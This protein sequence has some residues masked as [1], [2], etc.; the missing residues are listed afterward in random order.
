MENEMKMVFLTVDQ[1]EALMGFIEDGFVEGMCNNDKPMRWAW[2][3]SDVYKKL[4]EV[5][6]ND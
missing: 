6:T 1:C 2:N 3:M 5:T 4:L